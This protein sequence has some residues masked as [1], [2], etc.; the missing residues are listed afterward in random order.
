MT[1]FSDLKE[2][3]LEKQIEFFLMDNMV[4]V[5]QLTLNSRRD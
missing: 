2:D 1:L 5:D 4:G 3:R